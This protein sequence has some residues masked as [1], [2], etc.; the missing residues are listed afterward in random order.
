MR[1][2]APGEGE[3]WKR[4]DEEEQHVTARFHALHAEV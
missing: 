1:V 2:A 3:L 4:L